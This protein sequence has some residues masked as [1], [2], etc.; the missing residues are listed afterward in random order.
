MAGAT[1]NRTNRHGTDDDRLNEK[2]HSLLREAAEKREGRASYPVDGRRRRGEAG[3]GRPDRPGPKP[4]TPGP[5]DVGP[6]SRSRSR[7]RRPGFGRGPPVRPGRCR[8]CHARLLRGAAGPSVGGAGG[9]SGRLPNPRP[10]VPPRSWRRRAADDGAQR[11]L[12]RAR[13]SG[14]TGGL[15]RQG[16]ATA[17]RRR[18]RSAAVRRAPGPRLP[19]P[20]GRCYTGRTDTNHAGPPPGRPSGTVLDFGRYCGLVPR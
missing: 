6:R 20:F 7:S 13:R 14:S 4:G 5:S 10:Q 9:D 12:G 1:T 8:L 11:R 19:R 18:R 3:V 16:A 15:R 2:F 17:G